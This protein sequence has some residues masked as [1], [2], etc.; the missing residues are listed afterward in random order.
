M[1][2]QTDHDLIIELNAHG[3]E[4]PAAQYEE[5]EASLDSLREAVECFPTKSLY[6]TIVFHPK[7]RDYHV[8]T[9]LVL[10]GRTLFTGDRDTLVHPALERCFDK[11]LEKVNGFKQQLEAAE[12][13]K[14]Q[15][16][17]THHVVDS[18]MQ[19][20]TGELEEAR[21]QNDYLRFRRGLDGFTSA[22]SE[23]I[24]RWVQRYP[25]VEAA[26]GEG[27][28][29]SDL[30]EDVFFHAYESFDERPQEVPPGDWLE[31]LIDPSIQDFLRSPETELA[32][33]SYS[34][35]RLEQSGL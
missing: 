22:L 31:G 21:V 25:E 1:F 27:I 4:L 18:S 14:K 28:T 17:G 32:N 11:L 8:K 16:V 33:I 6:I 15:A 2:N 29:I 35:H 23:K 19:I 30:V 26:L 13:K 34:R 3:F 9:S 24:G 20:D 5:I 10:P 7:P 12:E